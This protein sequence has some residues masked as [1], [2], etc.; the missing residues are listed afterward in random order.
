L[1]GVRGVARE[2]PRTRSTTAAAALIDAVP[3]S[4]LLLIDDVIVALVVSADGDDLRDAVAVEIDLINEVAASVF[5][6]LKLPMSSNRP[7]RSR[8]V[9]VRLTTCIRAASAA[10]TPFFA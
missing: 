5:S 7:S 8:S 1:E 3:V 4:V 6:I 9:A 2:Q 10:L